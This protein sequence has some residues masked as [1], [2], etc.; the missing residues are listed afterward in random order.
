M[1]YEWVA[2]HNFFAKVSYYVTKCELFILKR[3]LRGKNGD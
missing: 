1:S 3:E 2:K